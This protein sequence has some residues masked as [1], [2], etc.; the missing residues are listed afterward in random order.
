MTHN[1]EFL[2]FFLNSF[3]SFNLPVAGLMYY[4]TEQISESNQEKITIVDICCVD[5]YGRFFIIEMQKQN[6]TNFIERILLNANKINSRQLK[7][8]K[9]YQKLIPVYTLCLVNE[10]IFP[11]KDSWMHDIFLSEL[12]QW[13]LN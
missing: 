12:Q 11:E 8:G 13:V 4:P 6:F 7:K 9:G 3:H 1:L 2:T 5:Q 10:N